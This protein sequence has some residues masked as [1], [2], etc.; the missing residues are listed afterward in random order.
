MKAK[1][2]LIVFFIVLLGNLFSQDQ[3]FKKDNTK[4]DVKILE[5]NPTEIKYK[6]KSNP[7]GPL[8]VVLKNEVALVIYAN[9]EHETFSDVKPAAAISKS[10]YKES[11]TIINYDSLFAKKNREMEQLLATLTKHKNIIFINTLGF[12]NSCI[13]LTIAREFM[14]GKMSVHLPV[15][16][17][18][19]KPQI[20]NSFDMNYFDFVSNYQLTQKTIDVG[21]GIYYHTGKRAVT[22]FIGPLYRFVQ[23]NGYFQSYYNYNNNNYNV[24][25]K[26]G[27]VMNESYL[28]VNNGILFR[29]TPHFSLMIH[30]AFGL[31]IQRDYIGNNPNNYSLPNYSYNNSNAYP[32]AQLG[33]HAGFRF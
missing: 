10:E 21:I 33:F 23:Y 14:K 26:H 20:S 18:Y 16:F 24:D 3:L 8:Y 22:H 2:S 13:S 25:S 7:E 5:I 17:S 1:L 19:N 28:M 12:A 30:G 31:I 29:I 27:F 15:S 11:T 9:G 6:L 32:I 4:L